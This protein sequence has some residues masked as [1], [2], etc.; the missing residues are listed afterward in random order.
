[1]AHTL[2]PGGT[3]TVRLVKGERPK[4]SYPAEVLGDDGGHLV[5]RAP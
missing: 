1:M 5:V 4:V 2:L 3:V